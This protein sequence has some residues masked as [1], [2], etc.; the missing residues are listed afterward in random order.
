MLHADKLYP[1]RLAFDRGFDDVAYASNVVLAFDH[2]LLERSPLIGHEH[3]VERT[4]GHRGR[5][6]HLHHL[7]SV[8]CHTLR[9]F[10]AI[11][12]THS[13]ISLHGDARLG[14]LDARLPRP[15]VAGNLAVLVLRDVFPEVPDVALLV[16]GVPVVGLLDQL[17]AFGHPVVHDDA[18]HTHDVLG[19]G[20]DVHGVT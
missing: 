13:R 17:A 3:V 9:I 10:L 12:L 7:G 19:V 14:P 1:L 2:A 18:L 11:R 6:I 20:R 5:S 8:L 4:V 15:F 16:L